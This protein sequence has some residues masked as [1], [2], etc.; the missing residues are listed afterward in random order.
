MAPLCSHQTFAVFTLHCIVFYLG[1]L[2]GS[3]TVVCVCVWKLKFKHFRILA[4][5]GTGTNISKCEV[6]KMT[7][8]DIN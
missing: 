4:S 8:K 3:C 2:L 7:L 1:I 6:L 5:L